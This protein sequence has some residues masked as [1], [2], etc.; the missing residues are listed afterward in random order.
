[1]NGIKLLLQMLKDGQVLPKIDLPQQAEVLDQR[2]EDGFCSRWVQVF[3]EI[4]AKKSAT[5][6]SPEAE[7]LVS[8]LREATYLKAFQKWKSSDLAACV[9]D[10]FGL[11]GD[12][13]VLGVDDAWVNG[14]FRAYA[15]GF[16]PAGRV[17]EVP[18]AL[19]DQILRVTK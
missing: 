17:S 9:S 7:A 11:V 14:L 16:V 3:T 1:M 18:D 2:D 5:Q 10:D 19:V 8:Q 4:E 15:S 6:L 13:L 12:C